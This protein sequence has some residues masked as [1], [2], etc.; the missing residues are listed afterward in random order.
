MGTKNQVVM[1]E[2][3]DD[4]GAWQWYGIYKNTTP[5]KAIAHYLKEQGLPREKVAQTMDGFYAKETDVRAFWVT[6]GT[7]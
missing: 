2:H 5:R 6:I 4:Y 7:I 1:V 3:I